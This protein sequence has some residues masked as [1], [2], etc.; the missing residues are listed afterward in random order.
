MK[1]TKT[2]R[3]K[4]LLVSGALLIALVGCANT[5]EKSGMYMDDSLIT[6][7]VKTQMATDKEVKAHNI[8]VNTSGG[9]V[10]LTGTAATMRESERAGQIAQNVAGVK[11]VK[12]EI[13]VQ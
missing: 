7:K 10:T 13:M 9:V 5:G 4:I 1:T 2:V 12:N 11:S 8:T 6:S 3:T